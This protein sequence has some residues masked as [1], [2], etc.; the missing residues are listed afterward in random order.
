MKRYALYSLITKLAVLTLCALFL[1]Q[2]Q[3]RAQGMTGYVVIF[4]SVGLAPG[5]SLRLTL[6][7]PDG[8]PVRAQAQIHHAGGVL[9]AMGDGSVRAGTF[10]T[11][12]FKRN[13]IPLPG[14]P[15]TGR[16]QLRY[17]VKLAFSDAIKPIAVSAEIVSILDGTSNTIF[18][19]EVMPSSHNSGGNDVLIGGSGRDILM[20]IIPGQTLRV[21]LFNPPSSDSSRRAVGGHVKIFDGSGNL[22]AQSPELT[23]P[24]DEFRHFDFD[25]NALHLPGDLGTGRLQ[26]RARLE[27]SGD[28]EGTAQLM[29]SLELIDNNNGRSHYYWWSESRT[30]TLTVTEPF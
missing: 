1:L 7:N 18:L 27:M 12:E 14:D 17:S 20:G 16:L 24:S 8:A 4:P 15:G 29:P 6:F 2:P 25:R 10:R 9:V 26:L 23:I 28:S 22:I 11:F 21:S 30:Y 3:A 19:G 13:D 5:Q